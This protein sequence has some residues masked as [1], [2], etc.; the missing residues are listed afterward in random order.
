MMSL[1]GGALRVSG[2]GGGNEIRREEVSISVLG[3]S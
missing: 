2:E 3:G 1:G